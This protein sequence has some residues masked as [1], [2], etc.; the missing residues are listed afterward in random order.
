MKK[1]LNVRTFLNTAFCTLAVGVLVTVLLAA[2][3]S[4]DRSQQDG[5]YTCPMHP[6]VVSDRP[7]SCPVCGMDLVRKARPGES[8]EVTED[9]AKLLRSPSQT[10]VASVNT[11][12]A[13]YRS[14]PVTLKTQGIV[15]YDTR[16][17]YTIPAR[18][19]GRLERVFLKY[20][21]Q[22]VI[23]GQKIA[24]IYSPEL[25]TAQ[26]ELLFLLKN[27]PDHASLIEAARQKLALL[28]MRPAQ[29][30]ALAESKRAE[31]TV[32]I[33]SPYS[34]YVITDQQAP[35]ASTA[36]PSAQPSGGGMAD[37][38]GTSPSPV[39]P[40]AQE[41]QGNTATAGPL[42]REG[43]YVTPG[44]T[45]FTVVNKNQLRIEL[46]LTGN[47]TGAVREG[48]KVE[49]NLGN[50]RKQIATI[51]FIQPFFEEGQE[52]VK[53]RVYTDKTDH[54]HIGQLVNATVQLDAKEA[55][56]VPQEAVFDLGIHKIVFLK[57]RGVLK[58]M[59][60]TTGAT[61]DGQVEIKAGLASSDEIAANAQFLVDS[62]SF[63]RV[64][65]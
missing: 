12:K 57:E 14:V 43:D 51:D 65:K 40:S 23:K 64:G 56:W 39:S 63:I 1:N 7:G 6:T 53:L 59:E 13:Q 20:P 26:R 41:S 36:M 44:E 19:G 11:I 52:F 16:N 49:L 22:P 42:V 58:P 35:S 28:G 37:G 25:I 15:T 33:Y 24:E 21:F 17:I 2:C 55:L 5:I 60:V 45:L 47:Y 10:V 4:N 8:V 3:N 18:V 46:N 54:L 38:M 61:S 50:D 34:G 29:I 48:S 30:N 9:L 27:D 31:T 62:E 32:S